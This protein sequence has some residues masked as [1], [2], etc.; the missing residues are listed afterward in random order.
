MDR[1]PS[2][3]TDEFKEKYVEI[4]SHRLG[5]SA[6]LNDWNSVRQFQRFQRLNHVVRMSAFASERPDAA[7]LM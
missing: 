3:T 7:N 1:Q 4:T 2:W 6:L 5:A